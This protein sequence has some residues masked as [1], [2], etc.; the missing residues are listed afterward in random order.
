MS[1][2][3]IGNLLGLAQ[4]AQAGGNLEEAVSYYNRVLEIDPRM[5]A[6]WLG[7]G[8]AV[9]WQSTLAHLRL[10]EALVA[11]THAIGSADPAEAKDIAGQ[12]AR[13]MNTVVTALHGLAQSHL[14]EFVNVSDV[15]AQHIGRN[16]GMIA[17]LESVRDW[18][19]DEGLLTNSTI[20]ALCR[21]TLEG[22]SYKDPFDNNTAKLHGV[23]PGY[24]A[25][26]TAKRQE[27]IGRIAAIIPNYSAPELKKQKLEEAACFV[28][29]ATMGDFEH[30]VVRL[31]RRYRDERMLRGPKGTRLVHG[32]YRVGPAVAA[33][34][35]R[36]VVLRRISYVLVVA[37]AAR[38]ARWRLSR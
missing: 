5:P 16:A 38:W 19:G 4:S 35:A 6:A 33:V 20:E 37:P 12:A 21:D 34:I 27:V 36:H 1:G 29:T 23:T 3:N 7:K 24:E 14:A 28:V 30:P 2:G 18:S 31:M 10:D 26:L 32:Y 13:T 8:E 25:D 22:R 15:W 17:A 9:A 11:F